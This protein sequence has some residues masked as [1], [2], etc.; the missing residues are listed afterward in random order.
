MKNLHNIEEVEKV[1]YFQLLHTKISGTGC[2]L[3]VILDESQEYP[4]L[5]NTICYYVRHLCKEAFRRIT[6]ISSSSWRQ[7]F[8][9]QLSGVDSDP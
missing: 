9:E 8:L 2:W 6:L 5:T 1:A 4:G 7:H 3:Y